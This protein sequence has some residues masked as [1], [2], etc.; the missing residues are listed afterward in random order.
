MEREFKFRAWDKERKEM[1][2]VQLMDFSDWWVSTGHTW[3]RKPGYIYGERNSFKNEDTDRHILMQYTGRKDKDKAEIYD[4]DILGADG[5]ADRYIVSWDSKHCCF[6]CIKE[7]EYMSEHDGIEYCL[8]SNMRL[9]ICK[10]VG[11]I[12]EVLAALDSEGVEEP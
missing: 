10:V 4:G 7:G 8:L 9:D 11:N 3:E 12:Y 6:V 2:Q 5:Y 1:R